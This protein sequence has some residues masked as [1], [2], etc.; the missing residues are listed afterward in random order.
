MH[1][2]NL[3]S[4]ELDHLI[5]REWL[6]V[7][8]IGGFA[9]ST[10][11]GLNARKYHG[12]LVAAMTPPVRRMVLLSRVEE[13][14][15]CD[16]WTS[17]LACNEYPGTFFP[18][19]DQ[20]LRAFSPDPFPRWAYQGDG[21]TIEKSL[22]LLNGENTVVLS[23]ALL[24]GDK[25]IELNLRPLLALRGMHELMYQWKGKLTAEEKSPGH[26][27]VPPTTRTPEVFFAH[28]G[29]FEADSHWYLNTVY[30]REQERGYAGREDLWN[31]GIIRWSLKPGQT[32]H[33]I[34]SADP[35]ELPRELAK[36]DRQLTEA[37]VP[38]PPAKSF[39][40]PMDSLLRAADQFVLS[41][42]REDEGQRDYAIPQYPW[43]PPSPRD[44]LIGF[45]GLFLVPGKFS[46]A[47]GLLLSMADHL[48]DGL[49]PSSLA[50]DG[51][52]A[53]FNGADVSLWFVNAVHEYLRY[54]ADEETVR[55]KLMEAVQQIIN[56]YRRGTSLGI[57]A[58]ADGLLETRQAGLAT[59]W[60][61]IRLG[62]RL[63][64]PRAGRPVE[65]N[66]LWYNAVRIA[67]KLAESF[68]QP[69]QAEEWAALAASIQEAFNRRFWNAEAACC[70]DVIDDQ[71]NDAAVR[72]N[73]L[74]AISLPYPVLASD[75]FEPVLEKAEAELL[76]PMG[77]RT[78]SPQSLDYQGHCAGNIIKRDQAYHQGSAFPWLLGAY[79][80]GYL[81]VHGHGEG[82]RG[83]AKQ[84]L[85]P[86]VQYLQGD[87]L[88]QLC[89]LF[90]GDKPHRPGGAIASATAVAELLRAY[91]EDVLELLPSPRA[92]ETPIAKA[93]KI[94]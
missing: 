71:Q 31:P 8:K 4:M 17:P 84:I 92:A 3:M 21:W 28:D 58:D 83:E 43:A 85:N 47:R 93:A 36:A 76:T 94:A 63:V 61:N 7:N 24:G 18:R 59:T 29:K 23:Y 19:G 11:P 51:G 72:P 64:T 69:E 2:L 26:H 41:V 66:A 42:P 39:G 88:G 87:G 40:E 68:G 89:E 50:E 32:V 15:I 16:G 35:I 75:R 60:M 81:R 14:V 9:C 10:V 25:S 46:A 6:A 91:A 52:P 13:T 27:R 20:S 38:S 86:C 49:L 70:F 1:A 44:T 33:F 67:A 78:L 74:L 48:V 90:D 54:T 82:A 30:R 45:A 80:T 56:C 62:E 34:C 55:N 77:L 5:D 37:M 53:V 57:R 12:L 79:V 73:Q 65:V 22:R